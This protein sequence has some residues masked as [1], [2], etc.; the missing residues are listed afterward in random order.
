MQKSVCML[1]HRDETRLELSFNQVLEGF[2]NQNSATGAFWLR[3]ALTHPQ[4]CFSCTCPSHHARDSA[5]A[6]FLPCK[7]LLRTTLVL[8]CTATCNA[9]NRGLG[10]T[11]RADAT[12]PKCSAPSRRDALLFHYFKT[13]L[14]TGLATS[15]GTHVSYAETNRLPALPSFCSR[16]PL[17][18]ICFPFHSF[19]SHSLKVSAG[20]KSIP[21]LPGLCCWK[22][23]R[24]RYVFQGAGQ[25]QP[26][27]ESTKPRGGVSRGSWVVFFPSCNLCLLS[28]DFLRIPRATGP[29]CDARLWLG[30][31]GQRPLRLTEL[32]TTP[33]LLHSLLPW[34]QLRNLIAFN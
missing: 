9:C 23:S 6:R 8:G 31:Q 15:T 21:W 7:L 5:F 33:S 29:G 2:G 19:T 28:W 20:L 13:L 3:S 26:A 11:Q 10:P 27:R 1:Q 16:Q 32:G 24:F 34:I 25:K 14:L 18:I 17:S 12:K 4:S 30:G 22:R